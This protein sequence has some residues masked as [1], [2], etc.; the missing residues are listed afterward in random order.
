MRIRDVLYSRCTQILNIKWKSVTN[1][2]RSERRHL[3]RL[4]N[5]TYCFLLLL[6]SLSSLCKPSAVAQPNFFFFLPGLLQNY[7]VFSC[8]WIQSTKVS[9]ALSAASYVTTSCSCTF[10]ARVCT[11]IISLQGHVDDFPENYFRCSNP[12]GSYVIIVIAWSR[13]VYPEKQHLHLV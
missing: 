2:G 8:Y 9:V 4:R 12:A 5:T 7:S 10:W 3:F 13:C 6:C 11:I 1:K